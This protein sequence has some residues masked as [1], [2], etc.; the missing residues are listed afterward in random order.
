M[1]NPRLAGRYAK[2][3]LDI[4][5][6]T[7]QLETIREDIATI[8]KVVASSH[9]FASLLKSPV[10]KADKKLKVFEAIFNGKV[11]NLMTMFTE[12][13]IKKGRE[14]F[15]SEILV[16]FQEEY[17]RLRGIHHISVRTAVALTPAMEKAI[18]DK[19][20]TDTGLTSVQ[21]HTSV[22]EDLIGGFV[23]EFENNLIDASVRK[24]LRQV[25]SQFKENTYIRNIR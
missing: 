18:V 23:I 15:L 2:S 16:A 9:E 25:K 7:N 24:Y 22:Q 10:I 17:D 5:K 14:K 12:L 11:S 6:E 13:L 1:Q 20:T 4:A 3:L 19:I 8:Q 21:L